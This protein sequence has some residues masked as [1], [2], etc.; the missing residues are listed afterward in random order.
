M[1][2][3]FLLGNTFSFKSVFSGASEKNHAVLIFTRVPQGRLLD[4]RMIVK[5]LRST[6]LL[7]LYS[8]AVTYIYK[9]CIPK[10]GRQGT[11]NAYFFGVTN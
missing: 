1:P 9:A 2:A 6:Y 10:R 4:L 3:D 8:F 7:V 5:W 11:R